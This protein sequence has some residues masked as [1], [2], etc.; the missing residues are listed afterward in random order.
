MA[1]SYDYEKCFSDYEKCYC[2]GG[3]GC[4][5]GGCLLNMSR[6]LLCENCKPDNY[7]HFLKCKA[8]WKKCEMGARF[9]Y[10]MYSFKGEEYHDTEC[11]CCYACHSTQVKIA[12]SGSEHETKSKSKCKVCNKALY[13]VYDYN[14]ICHSREEI[15]D[16]VYQEQKEMYYREW[17]D[18]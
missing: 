9:S 15:H 10:A 8:G 1:A 12:D 3:K 14:E 16:L 2:R 18:W 5:R 7:D 4:V 11:N 6:P 13:F 17:Y